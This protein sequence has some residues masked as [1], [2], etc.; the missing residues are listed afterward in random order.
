[1]P[2]DDEQKAFFNQVFGQMNAS[3]EGIR[4]KVTAMD[5]K[6]EDFKVKISKISKEVTDVREKVED[7][8]NSRLWLAKEVREKNIIIHGLKEPSVKSEL[9]EDQ[10]LDFFKKELGILLGKRDIDRVYRLGSKQIK[11]CP[12]KVQL[13]S[14]KIKDQITKNRRKL[15]G[16]GMACNDD[17]PKQL[18]KLLNEARFKKKEEALPSDASI[19][20][21]SPANAAS[22]DSLKTKLD[23]FRFG[24]PRITQLT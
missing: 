12:V 18:R 9:L 16:T 11:E 17:I 15:K 2:F 20:S 13:S 19:I 5:E 24:A 23:K 4:S 22:Q 14:L 21:N 1:M 7:E 3:L 10:V 8:V 6:L